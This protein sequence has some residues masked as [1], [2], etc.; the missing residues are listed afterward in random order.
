MIVT[1]MDLPECM[2]LVQASRL[3]RLACA[4]DG[5]PYVVPFNYAADGRDLYSFSLT[6]KKVEWMRQNP[7]VCVQID[8]LAGREWRSVV[9]Y[10]RFEE[11]PDEPGWKAQREHA[12]SLLSREVEWW[13]P[14]AFKP[15]GQGPAP[16]LFY[17]IVTGEVTG[18]RALPDRNA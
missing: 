17:R 10:G 5:Q 15:A 13:A 1:E 7:K 18:R 12:W 4:L 9:I 2:A 14:G 3:G 6:G 16:H 11:L 8:H